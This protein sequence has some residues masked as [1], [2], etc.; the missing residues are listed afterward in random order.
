MKNLRLGISILAFLVSIHF[1]LFDISKTDFPQIIIGFGIS[2]LA[3]I[4]LLQTGKTKLLWSV[5]MLA[6]MMTVFSI[7]ALSDDVYRFL[8]DGS[9]TVAGMNPFAVLPEDFQVQATDFQLFLLERMNS[10]TYYSVYPAVLQLLFASASYLFSSWLIGQVVFLKLL[11]L[12]SQIAAAYFL[13]SLLGLTAR[14]S[15]V[16]LVYFLNPLVIVELMGNMH[17]EVLMIAFLIASLYCLWRKQYAW[18][19]ILL[20]LSV[21]TK[22][23]TL[24]ILPFLLRKIWQK[25]FR[26]FSLAFT[27]SMLVLFVP[28]LYFSF[29]NFGQGLDL[30]F[31]KFEFNASVYYILRSI[32]YW[33]KGYNVIG[34]LGPAMA[35]VSGIS[36]LYLAYRKQS[37]SLESICS[38]SCIAFSIYL[39]LATT[40]HPW[41]ISLALILAVLSNL[42]Y[43]I[44]WSCLAILSYSKYYDGG[45]YYYLCVAI[46]YSLL[47]LLMYLEYL[48]Q[49]KIRLFELAK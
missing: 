16:A 5:S 34:S 17:F 15:K 10:P 14:N 18:A 36:I 24:M 6:S 45:Q 4:N 12:C 23:V 29:N 9:L 3:Y 7:P 39:L 48:R 35:V 20:A 43:P 11:L 38:A 1:L 47:F 27:L 37:I 49:P 33:I 2:F 25:G 21:G 30:Y 31:Q 44:Y 8:W 22:L 26:P 42:K 32:G 13:V 28:I 46:E 40:V 41:Y 19:G